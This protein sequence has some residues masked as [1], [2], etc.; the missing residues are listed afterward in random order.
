MP[1]A[2]RTEPVS[3]SRSGAGLGYANLYPHRE[4]M[5][6][7]RV[8]NVRDPNKPAGA[9]YIGRGTVAGNMFVIGKH[10]GRDAVCRAYEIRVEMDPELKAAVIEYCRGHDL[11]CHCAP[12]RCH[13]DY[14]L[15]ISNE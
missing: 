6:M 7:P 12:L 3:G 13:G 1:F 10:G 5:M 15:R 8:W 9:R 2:V 4:V 11:L 14:L